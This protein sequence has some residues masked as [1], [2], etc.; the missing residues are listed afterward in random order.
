M[1]SIFDG[2][3]LGDTNKAFQPSGTADWT[4]F[5]GGIMEGLGTQK[6]YNAAAA[7]PKAWGATIPK[8]G[9]GNTAASAN[10]YADPIDQF[11]HN[12]FGWEKEDKGTP[13][14][15]QGLGKVVSDVSDIADV[16][17][18]GFDLGPLI[19]RAA[20]II[21]GFIFVA[22]GLAMFRP[23]VTV[24]SQAKNLGDGLARGAAIG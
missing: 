3:N 11:L 19:G 15:V 8:I 1:A 24:I 20:V 23:G 4:S 12:V 5:Y 14:S 16:S 17:G 18:G 13:E 2:W 22:A 10:E 6:A 21:A 9:G 7:T